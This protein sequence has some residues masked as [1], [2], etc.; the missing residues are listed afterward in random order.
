M[1]PL[2]IHL[3]CG[4]Q[5]Q[6]NIRIT[7]NFFLIYKCLGPPHQ[8]LIFNLSWVRHRCKYFKR[9]PGDSTV[10]PI[11]QTNDK[12]GH[13]I[14]CPSFYTSWSYSKKVEVHSHMYLPAS[15]SLQMQNCALITW[16]RLAR[17]AMT[18]CFIF[19]FCV[20][21]WIVLCWEQRGNEY[22]NGLHS[23]TNRANTCHAS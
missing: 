2:I 20:E 6:L 18:I 17:E 21:M 1:Y 5:L 7:R 8:K 12:R 22:N 15:I 19:C 9:F 3:K 23:F 13:H 10:L 4:S 14:V 16:R 11:L